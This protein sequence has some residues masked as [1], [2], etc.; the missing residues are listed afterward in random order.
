MNILITLAI[1]SIMAVDKPNQTEPMIIEDFTQEG[2][3]L[4]WRIVN[5][6][7]MG[8]LSESTMTVSPDGTGIFEGTVSLDNNG[9]FASTRA[10]L[11]EADYS[12]VTKIRIKVRGDGQRYTFRVRTNRNFAGPA[13][14]IPF[15][16][17][18][19]TWTVHEFDLKD[20]KAQFRGYTLTDRPALTGDRMQQIGILI[21]DKQEG[22][23]W[24]EVDRIEGLE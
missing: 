8:G 9:G 18:K 3:K 6:G 11:K 12:A 16:T 22:G 14:V 17:E 15:D 24:L 2:S 4:D 23:F 1:I 10:L 20:F 5:D 13:Y 19:D 21:A 7:V